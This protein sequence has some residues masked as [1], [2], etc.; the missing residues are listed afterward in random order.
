MK[1]RFCNVLSNVAISLIIALIFALLYFFGFLP[2]IIYA[3]IFSLIL[4]LVSL[5]IIS[6]LGTSD[7]GL[8]RT[9]LC[10]RVFSILFSI[11]RK[12]IL[13]INC[14]SCCFKCREYYICYYSR[15]SYILFVTKYI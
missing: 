12:Y 14:I 6:I 7:N 15:I 3:I 4:A 13:G 10:H 2:G 8:T 9:A 5:L 1:E 11:V